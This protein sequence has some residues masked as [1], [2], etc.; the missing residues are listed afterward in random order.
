M[1]KVTLFLSGDVMTGRG[2]DQILPHPS[3]PR[4]FESALHDARDYVRLAERQCGPIPRGVNFTY[5]W[6]DALVELASRSPD[7][8]IV[9]LETS[10]TLS[11]A[12]EPKG[13]NYRMHPRNVPIL[14]AVGIQCCSLANNHVLDW[15]EAGLLDT[16]S[17]L[18]DAHIVTAGAGRNLVEARSPARFQVGP[19]GRIL[20]YSMGTASSGIP[21]SWAARD[22]HPGVWLVRD[23]SERSVAEIAQEVRLEKRPGDVALVSIHWGSNWGYT[24]PAEHRSL[25]HALIDE[26]AIDVVHGHSS[27]HPLGI[28]VH[29]GKL[30]LYGCG[31]FLNDYEGIVSH[32][33]F[34]PELSLMYFVTLDAPSGRLAQLELVPVRTRRFRLERPSAEETHWLETLLNREGTELGTHVECCTGGSFRLAWTAE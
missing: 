18:R 26:A 8:R 23:F 1:N 5:P 6:G 11:E 2:V 4:I 22:E 17:G 19:H 16:L 29:G 7:L 15:G 9:N 3:N 21:Q 10:I 24:I 30:I 28:E 14:Q 33:Q 31:D 27:H 12:A 20:V 25:A 13:I 34:R 32:R